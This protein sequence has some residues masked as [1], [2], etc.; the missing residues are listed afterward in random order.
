M[1]S[2]ISRCFKHS[3]NSVVCAKPKEALE[4]RRQN[5]ECALLSWPSRHH[6]K[7]PTGTKDTAVRAALTIAFF[8]SV[9]ARAAVTS[10]PC[11]INKFSPACAQWMRENPAVPETVEF[12]KGKPFNSAYKPTVSKPECFNSS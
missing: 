6:L 8:A 1:K 10:T 5:L 4:E 12:R 3:T 11:S 2:Q 9:I 7:S